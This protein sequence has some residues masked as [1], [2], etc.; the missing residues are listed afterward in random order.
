MLRLFGRIAVRI[1][2]GKSDMETTRPVLEFVAQNYAP[3][4]MMLAD[5]QDAIGRGTSRKETIGY[6]RR[7]LETA[8]EGDESFDAFLRLGHL[9]R[10]EG[11][12]M[13][14]TGAY[15]RA[16]E[17]PSASI[18]EMSGA[19]SWLNA[20]WEHL[21]GMDSFDKTAMYRE[22]ARVMERHHSKFSATDLSRLAWLHLHGG[23]ALRARELAQQGL[24]LEPANDH[25]RRI[26]ERLLA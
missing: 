17:S 24:A 9:Y 1:L 18:E 5:L 4:W 20:R 13:G 26:L 25:C 10:W 6:I 3:A 12:A 19:A 14:A 7:Y 22:L 11:D 2:D 23:D 16:F 8:P 21:H 15:V